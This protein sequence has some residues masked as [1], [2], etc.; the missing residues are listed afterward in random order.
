MSLQCF[1]EC[2]ALKYVRPSSL[3][4]IHTHTH[5][6]L[7]YPLPPFRPFS[8]SITHKNN[9]I[10]FQ[11]NITQSGGGGIFSSKVSASPGAVASGTPKGLPGAA[12][13]VKTAAEARPTPSETAALSGGVGSRAR[14]GPA[15]TEGPG[16]RTGATGGLTGSVEAAKHEGGARP[17][18][19]LPAAGEKT[20]GRS[21]SPGGPEAGAAGI[22]PGANNGG[23]EQVPGG[24]TRPAESFA[25]LRESLPTASE[26]R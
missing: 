12:D 10:I 19:P 24:D 2:L 22:R 1:E 16:G 25:R 14:S 4:R 7:P 9:K 20:A 11:P 8:A 5:T 3:Y 21:K 23:P 15:K 26:F 6:T 17:K 13:S 18:T